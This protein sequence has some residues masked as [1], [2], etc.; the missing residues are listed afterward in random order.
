MIGIGQ[1]GIGGHRMCVCEPVAANQT[2]IVAVEAAQSVVDLFNG[3][4]PRTIANPKVLTS[5]RWRHL[6]PRGNLRE[7]KGE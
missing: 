5:D 3:T 6:K 2:P 1:T 7:R 4:E